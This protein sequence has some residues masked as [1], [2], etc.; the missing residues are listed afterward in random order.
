MIPSRDMERDRL[1]LFGLEQLA[2]LE[3]YPHG[4][5]TRSHTELQIKHSGF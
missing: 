5:D 1:S 2:N 4:R 3:M